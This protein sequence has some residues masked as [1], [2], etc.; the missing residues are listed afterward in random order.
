MTIAFEIITIFAVALVLFI[1][2]LAWFA[3]ESGRIE[4]LRLQRKREAEA[5][6]RLS[7]KLARRHYNHDELID[8][9]REQSK[10]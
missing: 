7:R 5:Q 3:R 8:W 4:S 9:L 1:M 6:R 2:A 10:D